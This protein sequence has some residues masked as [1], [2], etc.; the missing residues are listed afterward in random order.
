MRNSA[1]TNACASAYL[2]LLP[3]ETPPC[4]LPQAG[5][6]KRLRLVARSP[7]PKKVIVLDEPT[8]HLGVRQAAEVLDVIRQAREEGLAVV[9]ISHT[10]PQVL[11]LAD[12]I[13]VLRLGRVAADQPTSNFTHDALVK[14]I[15]G[16]K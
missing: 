15:T 9:F 7:G 5:R 1:F 3:H 6:V 13:V 8:N 16:L 14:A 4:F 2:N 10:L 12:R 11:E